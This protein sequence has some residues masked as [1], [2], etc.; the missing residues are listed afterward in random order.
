LFVSP[1]HGH[2][3]GLCCHQ[4]RNSISVESVA[5]KLSTIK[6]EPF[7]LSISVEFHTN[8]DVEVVVREFLTGLNPLFY[9]SLSTTEY[10]RSYRDGNGK[11]L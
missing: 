3:F 11:D 4:R 7:L 5:F 2:E 8:E 6:E 10:Y 9:V 1:E